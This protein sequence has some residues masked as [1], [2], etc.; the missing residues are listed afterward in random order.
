[1]RPNQLNVSLLVCTLDLQLH[2]ERLFGRVSQI[3]PATL[4]RLFELEVFVVVLSCN[5]ESHFI[6]FQPVVPPQDWAPRVSVLHLT[7]ALCRLLRR[8]Q[9]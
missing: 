6:I 5:D 4:R 9:D 2:V 8:G 1:M 3:C 7:D